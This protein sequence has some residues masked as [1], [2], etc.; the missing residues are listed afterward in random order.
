MELEK[1]KNLKRIRF[2]TSHPK[3]MNEKLINCYKN[4][5]K[6]MPFLNLHDK[7]GS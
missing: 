5:K 6:L 7:V 4:S 2:T 1:I 3:D